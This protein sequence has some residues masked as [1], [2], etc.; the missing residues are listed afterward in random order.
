MGGGD[1]LPDLD[2]DV[3]CFFSNLYFEI[4]SA[5]T[6]EKQYLIVVFTLRM[7]QQIVMMRVSINKSFFNFIIYLRTIQNVCMT[8]HRCLF[9]DLPGLE[10]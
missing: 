6:T 8:E 2:G 5:L 9:P 3:R 1:D 10:D 7:T 4:D